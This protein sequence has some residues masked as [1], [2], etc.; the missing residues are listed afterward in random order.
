MSVLHGGN[1][2]QCPCHTFFADPS[3]E[4]RWVCVCEH[5]VNLHQRQASPPSAIAFEGQNCTRCPCQFHFNP[6]PQLSE[7]V[8]MCICGHP[9][10]LHAMVSNEISPVG[11]GRAADIIQLKVVASESQPA[12]PEGIVPIAKT[13]DKRT[14]KSEKLWDSVFNIPP[15]DSIPSCPRPREKS[16]SVKLETDGKLDRID[17]RKRL[18]VETEPAIIDLSELTPLPKSISSTTSHDHQRSAASSSIKYGRDRHKPPVDQNSITIDEMPATYT[19]FHL[20]WVRFPNAD[21]C[22][23][24]LHSNAYKRLQSIPWASI[25]PSRSRSRPLGRVRQARDRQS[26][27]PSRQ[28]NPPGELPSVLL[29]TANRCLFPSRRHS[30]ECGNDGVSRE[31]GQEQ[32]VPGAQ[33]TLS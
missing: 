30:V 8:W 25:Y 33:G 15:T 16:S 18:K 22:L 17:H 21:Q 3:A 24:L 2:N 28:P 20:S 23:G 13:K 7:K 9:F 11:N 19:L 31:R 6:D 14:P 4:K 5:T 12:V 1:C 29:Q 10:N 32:H 26:R 27:C